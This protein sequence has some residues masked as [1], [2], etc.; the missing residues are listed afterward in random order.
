MVIDHIN[1]HQ[2]SNTYQQNLHNEIY[3]NIKLIKF[4]LLTL[5]NNIPR[6]YVFRINKIKFIYSPLFKTVFVKSK[7]KMFAKFKI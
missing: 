6:I 3:N 4:F 2:Y 1:L 7:L 5:N